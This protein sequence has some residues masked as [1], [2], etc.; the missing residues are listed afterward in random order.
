MTNGIVI[1]VFSYILTDS[2]LTYQRS[3]TSLQQIATLLDT[4]TKEKYVLGYF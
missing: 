4:I 1:S 2:K 3:K